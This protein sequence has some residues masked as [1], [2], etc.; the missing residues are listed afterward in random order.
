MLHN[1]I[2]EKLPL[3]PGAYQAHIA[4]H[5][6]PELGEF[7][8]GCLAEDLA[9]PGDARVIGHLEQRAVGLV[10]IGQFGEVVLGVNDHG[11]QFQDTEGL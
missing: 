9:D 11:A 6:V 1:L 7:V 2:D 8:D 5:H 4:A 10:L 3:G